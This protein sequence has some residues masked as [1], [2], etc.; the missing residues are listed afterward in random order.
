MRKL[1]F[2]S[3]LLLAITF[4]VVNCTKEGPEG[5]VGATGPQGP[6]GANGASG[7]NGTNGTNGATGATGP[8]GPAGATGPAGTA[9]VIYSAW[10]TP[11]IYTSSTVFGTDHWSYVKTAPGITQAILDNGAIL[12]YG[13][14]NGYNT[15]V[16]P[17]DQVSLLPIIVSYQQSSVFQFDTW[18]SLTT[19]GNLK[20]DF[21]NSVNFYTGGISNTHQFR[22]V[23][24]P[25][26]VAGGRMANGQST[27]FGYTENQLKAM[28]YFEV[29]KA[30]N[31]PE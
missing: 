6:A 30:L 21:V 20:I 15:A 25:G 5:P 13:K 16:W 14:L 31:I 19:V 26:G 11:N 10:F 4:I 17:T 29:C 27:Y 18:S 28:S 24:I 3:L 2:L 22:Y 23:I 7:T 9:N 12:V 8:Q 1:R